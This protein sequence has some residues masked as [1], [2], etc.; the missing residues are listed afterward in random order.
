MV[1]FL[2]LK[3]VEKFRF[4]KN[5]FLAVVGECGG[6]YYCVNACPEDAIKEWMPPTVDPS[7]CTRCLKCVEACPRRVMQVVY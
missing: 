7:R 6:C 1:V 5:V 3:D 4:D 2:G